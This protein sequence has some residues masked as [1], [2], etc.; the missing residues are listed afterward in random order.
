MKSHLDN[1]SFDIAISENIEFV[2]DLT[3]A[4]ARKHWDEV[5]N[6]LK[7]TYKE[8]FEIL[9][10]SATHAFRKAYIVHFD[11]IDAKDDSSFRELVE[12]FVAGNLLDTIHNLIDKQEEALTP[13]GKLDI[14]RI[15][16]K[17]KASKVLKNFNQYFVQIDHFLIQVN[18]PKGKKKC[19]VICKFVGEEY[20]I[21][22]FQSSTGIIVSAPHPF[23]D[24]CDLKLVFSEVGES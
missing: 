18:I 22:E 1:E 10:K 20:E 6:K 13:S 16:I 15:S 24:E 7:Y 17:P 8:F 21:S 4:I 12:K 14:G 5:R 9:A 11:N 23:D 2:L 3:E 19:N